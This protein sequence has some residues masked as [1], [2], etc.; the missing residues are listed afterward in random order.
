MTSTNVEPPVRLGS[1]EQAAELLANLPTD[2]TGQTIVM[3]FRDNRS[4]RPSFVDEL[5]REVLFVRNACCLALHEPPEM[6][7]STA[8]RS[9]QSRGLEARLLID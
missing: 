4:A 3:S 7:S 2:L 6:V 5:V 1:R 8:L 9:A